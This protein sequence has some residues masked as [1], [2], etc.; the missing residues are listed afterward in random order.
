MTTGNTPLPEFEYGRVD[1]DPVT[2]INQQTTL[3]TTDGSVGGDTIVIHLSRGL[4]TQPVT[5]GGAAQP[6]PVQGDVFANT[7]GETRLLIGGGGTGLITVI[8]DSSPSEYTVY[9]NEACAPNGEPTARLSATPQSGTAPLNVDFDGSASS[10]PDAGDTIAE[11]TFD[12]GDGT[13]PVTQASPT[14]DHTYTDPGNYNAS[15]KVKD[16]RGKSSTNTANVV[17][18]V[19]PKGDYY[20]VRPCRL[21]DTRS[22]GTPAQ[23]GSDMVLD[24]DAVT[25]C[26]VSPLATAV[27][28]NITVDQ[29]SGPGHL[30]AYPGDMAQPPATSTVNFRAGITRSN[31]A[32]MALSGDGRIKLRPFVTGGGSVHLIVDVVGFFIEEAP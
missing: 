11:Y 3:G 14:V 19:M 20:T 16:S 15:L 13:A 4:L 8:D 27:A 30:I 23:S 12:F 31:N 10:D 7:R 28:I 18:Q 24:V 22:G 6:A 5:I 32:L 2:G 9:T 29:P 26:G 17:I 1:P 21:L 25:P